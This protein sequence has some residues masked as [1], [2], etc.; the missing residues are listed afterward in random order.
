LRPQSDTFRPRSD[1]FRPETGT[2]RPASDTL[3]PASDPSGPRSRPPRPHTRPHPSP[4]SEVARAAI[5]YAS[6]ATQTLAS[7]D[8]MRPAAPI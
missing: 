6:N 5:A 7:E 1:T 8:P 4:P 3:R 2:L